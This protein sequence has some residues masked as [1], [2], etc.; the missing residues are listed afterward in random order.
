MTE[1]HSA[2]TRTLGWAVWVG[3][4]RMGSGSKGRGVSLGGEKVL[5]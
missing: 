5:K 2:V 3:G 1:S 4:G